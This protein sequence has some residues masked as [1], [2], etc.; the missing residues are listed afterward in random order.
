MPNIQKYLNLLIVESKKKPFPIFMYWVELFK[1]DLIRKSELKSKV[2]RSENMV[3]LG[4]SNRHYPNRSCARTDLQSKIVK[5]NPTNS[6][7]D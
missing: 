5:S 3:F 4:L 7:C 2:N 6:N 1:C